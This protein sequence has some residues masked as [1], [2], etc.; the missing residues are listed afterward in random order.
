[1]KKQKKNKKLNKYELWEKA[2]KGRIT[3]KDLGI[4]P[5]NDK[6]LSKDFYMDKR[7]YIWTY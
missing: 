2:G 7:R 6:E 3:R 5:S 1:M 4:S